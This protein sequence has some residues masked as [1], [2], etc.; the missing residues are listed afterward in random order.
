MGRRP[1]RCYRYCKNKPYP[2]SR[3]C[4]GVPDAKIRIFDL[5]RKKAK[6]DEF[7]L[8][9]HMVS[10]EYEQLSSEALEAARICA[11]KYMVKS[12]GKDGF[13]IRVRLHP[14]HVIRINKMLSCAG[15]DRST[16]Q[17]S[18]ASPSSMLMNLKTWWL[19]SGSSQMAVGSSTS[20][21]VALWTSGGPC[22]H[23]G[24]Q[25]AAPL[26]ILTN[27]FYFLST[28]VFVSTFLTGKELPLGTFGSLPF[29]FRNRLTTQPCS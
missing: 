11:N 20:P 15:A 16:S 26:L 29:H 10:D 19:K 17:R 18:G 21:V 23:E 24:F 2:K 9:G 28:Y 14:F 3:F 7:P 12:C 4:R 13:H 1:A 25:C 22:T 6:V 8:C 5:G 27:K